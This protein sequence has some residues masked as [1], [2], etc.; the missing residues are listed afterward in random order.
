MELWNTLFG[1]F[2]TWAGQGLLDAGGWTL[3][4]VV[5]LATHLT[6]LSV[7]LFLHRAQAHRAL[8]LHPAVSHLMRFWLWLTT[9]I[10]TREWVAIHRKHHAKCETAEDPHSPVSKGLSTVLLRGS[11]LYRAEA[12]NPET[13]AKYSHGVPNDWMERHVYT[14]H[15]FL[16]VALLLVLLLTL[17]GAWGASMWA[18]IMAWIPIH[19]AGIINGLGHWW[20]Y[21]NFESPDTSTNLT[22]LAL[23]IG[24]E[25]LHNNHHTFPTSAKFSVRRFEVDIG[26]GYIRLLQAFGLARPR[27][28]PPKVVEGEIQ[29]A[30]R[31]TLEVLIANRYE[32]MAHFGRELRAAC[33]AELQQLKAKGARHSEQWQQFKL[34][35]RWL[36]RD[37]RR[38]PQALDLQLAAARAA[39]PVL[40]Q[41]VTMR[42]ELRA[43]WTRTNVSAEQLVAELQAWCQRAEASGIAELRAVSVRL[44]ASRLAASAL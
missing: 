38:I 26:W 42:E 8:D 7:T 23:W 35:K 24:G 39:S 19:A 21:R 25:E 34:A 17:F 28:L 37:S 1:A 9:G 16:G 2:A 36:P 6:I 40:E 3:L 27:K 44:R 41:M 30:D 5:L 29:P 43:L 22:P 4:A 32:V 18:L 12:K 10:V 15:S 11:E 33:R 20:G 13:L 14:R 31:R